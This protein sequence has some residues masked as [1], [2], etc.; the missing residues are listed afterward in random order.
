MRTVIFELACLALFLQGQTK[1]DLRTQSKNVDF[2]N[3]PTSTPWVVGSVAP[4][5][6]TIGQAFFNTSAVAGANLLLCTAP[7]QWTLTGGVGS[8]A[9][10][11]STTGNGPP[12]GG[13]TAGQNLY[14]DLLNQDFWSCESANVWK[15]SLTTNNI[16]AFSMTGQN[17]SAPGAS[18]FGATSLFFSATAK[19]AQTVDDAGSVATMV[20][21]ADCSVGNQSVQRINADGT[22]TCGN[23][24]TIIFGAQPTCTV[25]LRGTV[26]ETFGPSG[27]KDTMSVCLKDAA[28][29]FAWRTLY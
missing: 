22:V 25:V 29:V 5:V 8:G 13:C 24:P 12:L 16:G 14:V 9:G 3:A 4:A 19:V 20:R 10:I 2:S 17:G 11:T 23:S 26:W 7:N 18:T 6:C 27:Q 15:K 28:D 21:P 1:I